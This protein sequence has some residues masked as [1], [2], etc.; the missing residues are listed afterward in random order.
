MIKLREIT[1]KDYLGVKR[2][3]AMMGTFADA[4]HYDEVFK[5]ESVCVRDTA[6][7]IVAMYLHEVLPLDECRKA[8]QYLRKAAT[9][10]GNRGVAGG[11]I[12]PAKAQGRIGKVLGNGLRYFPIRKDGTLSKT[13]R[14]NLVASG[15]VGAL[16]GTPRF[17]HC[18]LTAFTVDHMAEYKKSMPYVR[19]VNEV[20]KTYAPERYAA[21]LSMATITDPNW[22]IPETAFSTITVNHNFRTAYH[23]DANDYRKGLGVLSVLENGKYEGCHLVFP[24][25]RVAFDLRMGGVC[26]ANVHQ[27]HGNTD[28]VGVPNSYHRVSC[29]FYYR[30]NIYKCES[31]E[32]EMKKAVYGA[33]RMNEF[34]RRKKS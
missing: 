1:V 8:M 27:V 6:G 34:Q 3:K 15:V 30:E 16:D 24:R 31:P 9:L 17:P 10:A 26:L 33:E 14:A 29:V 25:Y 23:E 21:Q 2:A 4:S 12:D 20:F 11:L 32:V 22:L 19:A 18:R 13:N 5:G 7:D 28:F